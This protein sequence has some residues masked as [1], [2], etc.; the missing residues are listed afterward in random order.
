MAGWLPVS[1]SHCMYGYIDTSSTHHE[2][3]S[4]FPPPPFSRL[5]LSVCLSICLVVRLSV[6]CV[7][8]SLYLSV[9]LYLHTRTHTHTHNPRGAGGKGQ[10]SDLG[11]IVRL[12][13]E[14]NYDPVIIFSFSKRCVRTDGRGCFGWWWW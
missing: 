8:H 10:Q 12:I 13:M 6:V 7:S 9:C 3:R 1:L 4:P 2:S 11:K 5:T 14:R